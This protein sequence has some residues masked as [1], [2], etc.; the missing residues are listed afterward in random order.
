M[1]RYYIYLITALSLLHTGC[2]LDTADTKRPERVGETIWS[3][4]EYDLTYVNSIFRD[5]AHLDNMLSIE[6][7]EERD[8]YAV[9]NFPTATVEIGGNRHVI[10]YKTN[11][12]TFYTTTIETDGVS[13]SDGGSWHVKCSA[14]RGYDLSVEP[15]SRGYMATFH[16]IYYNASKGAAQFNVEFDVVP[17]GT[18]DYMQAVVSY[19]G[20]L[21][22]VDSE[23]SERRPITLTT[24]ITEPITYE[25][26]FGMVDGTMTITCVDKIYNSTDVVKV[27]IFNNPRYIKLWYGGAEYRLFD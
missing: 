13:L 12:D 3:V 2:T 16:N 7:A 19:G 21:E 11:Y 9:D 22:V 23:A 17:Y 10:R 25:E 14:G 15:S 24:E 4:V 20:S 26:L 1:R 6:S 18:E 27:M 5:L 8:A